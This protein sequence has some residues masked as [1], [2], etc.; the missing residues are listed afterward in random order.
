VKS[1]LDPAWATQPVQL[2]ECEGRLA[3]LS[4]DPGGRVLTS[5]IE[6]PRD[7]K[8]FLRV[9]TGLAVSVGSNFTDDC[10]PREA[11]V[12]SDAENFVAYLFKELLK[13][14]FHDCRPDEE[15]R[16]SA[17]YSMPRADSRFRKGCESGR[18]I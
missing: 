14:R 12:L 13:Q 10:T 9:A 7:V 2:T 11:R 16:Q 15:L 17:L 8:P 5:P 4:R 3:L 18:S 6:K 1:E